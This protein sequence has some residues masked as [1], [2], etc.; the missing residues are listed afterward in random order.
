[1]PYKPTSNIRKRLHR[2][3]SR[4]VVLIARLLPLKYHRRIEVVEQWERI[5]E[6]ISCCQG[7]VRADEPRKTEQIRKVDTPGRDPDTARQS[8]DVV[9]LVLCYPEMQGDLYRNA[10][11][12]LRAPRNDSS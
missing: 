11:S 5:G 6:L 9:D 2:E 10:R 8:C 4:T 7:E 1:M 12:S 3:T